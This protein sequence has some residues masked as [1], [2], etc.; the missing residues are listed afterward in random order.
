MS[1][2]AADGDLTIR[3]TQWEALIRG[4]QEGDGKIR[5]VV[6]QA[7][8]ALFILDCQGHIVD[9]N[10]RACESLGYVRDEL[11]AMNIADI[12]QDAARPLHRQKYWESLRPGTIAIFEGTHRRKDGSIFPVEVHLGL[13][14]TEG[15]RLMLGF[16]RDVTERKE[17]EAAL[18]DERDRARRYFETAG[19]MLVLLTPDGTV[20]MINRKGCE[21][22]KRDVS[23]IVGANWFDSFLPEAIREQT[24]EV[25]AALMAGEIAPVEYHENPVVDAGGREK[26]IAWHNTVLRD[27]SGRITAVLTSGEDITERRQVEAELSRYREHLEELVEQR[28]AELEKSREQ[29]RQSE[30]LAS[31]GTLA[32]GIAHEVNNPVGAILL[33]AELA[34]LSAQDSEA[35]REALTKIVGYARR[36]KGIIH[37]VL[38]LARQGASEMACGDLNLVIARAAAQN[39]AY[40]ANAGCRIELALGPELPALMLNDLEIEEAV[41]NLVRNAAEAHARSV[42]LSTD[43]REGVAVVEV[44]DDGDGMPQEQ[45]DRMFDP[46]FTTRRSSGGTGLGLSIVHSVVRGHGGTIQVDTA[47]GKGTLF[48][49]R[50]PLRPEVSGGRIGS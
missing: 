31:V 20:E 24:R 9:V 23:E 49:L 43:L 40:A 1:D 28:S 48:T 4:E 10:R 41:G 18:R 21:V 36:A 12:D 37:D 35:V 30:H 6:D 29:L 13:L 7:T 11:L 19:T 8:D 50:L 44:R 17:G 22:L 15:R 26:L 5:A 14:Q 3:T 16:A 34:L 47:L 27:H 33:A 45:S 2:A 25:F 42:R 46:F 38:L 39:E 32:A